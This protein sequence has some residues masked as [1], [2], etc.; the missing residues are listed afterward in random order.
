MLRLTQHGFILLYLLSTIQLIAQDKLPCTENSPYVSDWKF[1]GP[2]NT[3]DEMSNQHFG[4]VRSISVNPLDSNEI[5]VGST[6]GGLFHTIDR[7]KHW[8]CLTCHNLLPILGINA[9]EVDYRISPHRIILATGSST[10]W[11]DAGNFGILISTDGGQQW[12]AHSANSDGIKFAPEIKG[13][14]QDSTLHLLFAY[15]QREI[16]RSPDHGE[17]WQSI[18][19]MDT[20]RLQSFAKDD[21][22]I[23]LELDRKRHTLFF[24]T[25]ASPSYTAN[26][27]SL[28][29][30]CDFIQITHYDSDASKRQCYRRNFLLDDAYFIPSSNPSFGLKVIK[31]HPYSDTLIINR[32]FHHSFEHLIYFFDLNT[33]KIVKTISPNNHSLPEDIYW[34]AGLRAHPINP[35]IL[36][37]ACNMLYKSED[38]GKTFLPCYSYS[39]GNNNVPHADI[40]SIYVASSSPDGQHDEIY[41]GTD[42][43]LSYSSNSGKT[44]RNLNGTSLPIT[45]FYGLSVSPF[46]GNITAGSQ[47]NSIM[48]YLPN[49]HKWIVDIRGDGYDIEYSKRIPGKLIGEYNANR[50]H[51]SNNDV[52]PLTQYIQPSKLEGSCNKKSLIAHKNGNF[53]LSGNKIAKLIPGNTHWEIFN[54]QLPNT[55]LSMAVAETDTNMIYISSYWNGLYKSSD[56]GVTFNDIS[57]QVAINNSIL[58]NTRIHSITISP[59]NENELWIS[60]GYLGDYYDV[61]KPTPRVLHSEDGGNSWQDYSQGLPVYGVSDIVFLEGSEEALFAAT[62]DG[63]YFREHRN[64]SWKLFST[65]LPKSIVPEL[66]ISYCRGKLIAA[67]YGH[68]LWETDLPKIKF[69]HFTHIR[70]DTVWRTLLKNEAFYSTTD[71]IVHKGVHWVLEGNLHMAKGKAIY[72]KKRAQIEFKNGATIRNDCQE[73]WGGIQK[74]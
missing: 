38:S 3:P 1:L 4:A 41:I 57:N 64:E 28:V 19:S 49:E 30:E 53:Y 65:N 73:N 5:Y 12:T 46:S 31:Q 23:S 40:R 13:F 2:F 45:Q 50:V 16:F 43:G 8:T 51:Q 7:G 66:A 32:T 34:L 9:I 42:G 44:F 74:K 20:S 48:S 60:L 72:T 29:R 61:C 21:E 25:H 56:G 69:T 55:V 6:S 52:A 24:T 37:L 35:A 47:D 26:D 58:G 59:Y 70:K 33:Q 27:N 14:Q 39:F 18:F 11:Y 36:Y 54:P 68:G 63:V 62:F 71:I 22:I 17:H 10:T 67:T 15:S